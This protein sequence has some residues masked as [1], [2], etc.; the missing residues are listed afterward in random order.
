LAHIL[1]PSWRTADFGDGSARVAW[2]SALDPGEKKAYTIN[3]ATEL[4]S[5]TN[6]IEI[7]DITLSGLAVVAGLR[8]LEVTYDRANVTVWLEIQ[9]ADKA[10]SNWLGAGETH[11]MT[12]TIDVTDGQRFERDV[13]LQIKQLGQT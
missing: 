7:V 9:D 13:S 5:A 6:Q 12:C 3:C 8:I 10:K 11:F 4:A 1:A 2:R